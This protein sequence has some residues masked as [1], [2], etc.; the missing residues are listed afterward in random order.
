MHELNFTSALYLGFT[1]PSDALPAWR[2]LTTG[3]PAVLGSPS[4]AD[5][6]AA[7]A[8]RLIGAADAVVAP[9]TLH[10]AL[11]LIPMLA[12][13]GTTMFF[14][15]GVYPISH[16]GIERAVTNGARAVS[17]RAH[18]PRALRDTLALHAPFARPPLVVCDGLCPSCGRLA[19]LRSYET[20]VRS[21]GGRIVVDDTQAIGILGR[22]PNTEYPYGCGGGGT[23]RLLDVPMDGVVVFASLAKGFGAPLAIVAGPERVIQRF[24]ENADTRAHC[25]PPS[26]PVLLAAQRALA[27]NASHGDLLRRRLFDRV[28]HFRRRFA[29]TG[30]L[31]ST[32]H[33]PV[34]PLRVARPE[35]ARLIQ[36]SLRNH[37]VRAPLTRDHDGSPLVTFVLTAAHTVRAIDAAA[38]LTLSLLTGTLRR[39]G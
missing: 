1:H 23:T 17:F 10:V 32:T 38:A 26:I 5:D 13:P 12:P 16:W 30:L 19:P 7:A 33:F 29:H 24:R 2:Q 37:G 9:S 4:I 6:V 27:L 34:Q 31:T 36:R 39:A 22:R 28:A 20:V 14:D 15:A 11:D 18:D 35:H 25:S 21:H 3:V 8:A